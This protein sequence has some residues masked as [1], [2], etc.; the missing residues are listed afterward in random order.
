MILIA[1]VIG[2]A[3]LAFART[4]TSRTE[5]TNI[6][7]LVNEVKQNNVKTL[8]EAADYSS[9]RVV[10]KTGSEFVVTKPSNQNAPEMLR[11]SYGITAD[12]LASFDY[13]V[14]TVPLLS[15]FFSSALFYLLPLLMIGL[16]FF[17]TMRRAQT[18]AD[19][20]FSFG[21]SKARRMSSETPVV[22]FADVAGCDEAK[23]ELVEVVEF[24]KSP[25][26]FIQLG[27]R[28]P[29]GVL[30]VGPPGSGKTLLAKAVAG[31]AGVPFFSLSGS[32]F[33]ELFVGVGASRVRD[34]FEQAK[35]ASPCI[36][37]IDEI[38]AV[39]RQRGAGLGGGNDEREQTLNQMLVE[40]DGFNTE[41]NVIVIAA[42]NRPDILDPALLR[43]GRFDRRVTVDAPDVLGREQ[44][45]KVHSRG[46]PIAANVDMKAIA[47]QTPGFTGADI[48]NLVNEA[49]ILT[50]R[51]NRKEITQKELQEAIEKVA[52]GPERKS[53]LIPP[54]SKEI[55]AYHEAGHA[56]SAA[57]LPESNLSLQKV[58]II[59]RGQTGGAAWYAPEEEDML[60]NTT[61][62]SIEARLVVSMAGRAA[63]EIMF[64]DVTAGAVA[65]IDSAS[66]Q[67]RAMVRRYG[68][69]DEIGPVSFGDRQ[70]LVFLGRELSE[71]RNYSEKV[72]ETIDNEVIKILRTAY[73]RSKQLLLDNKEKF[74]AVAQALLERESLDSVEFR[75]IM[76]LPALPPPV[77]TP[78]T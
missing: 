76:G 69:S 5:E 54:K 61:R 50:A 63:E 57:M 56:V 78:G 22:T 20:A 19:Q 25:E 64:G 48:E 58:S 46:K 14:E 10:R 15:Q 35:K 16:F 49:A 44:I 40:M 42:T 8:L 74:V 52:L 67:A 38:D 12:Q 66:S 24:L 34:L 21:R 65:D 32:E 55:I 36:I 33:V 26:K 62:K 29:K 70:E 4:G 73:Q 7:M 72:A 6:N 39:G 30:L 1:L 41:T 28:I 51:A 31:E 77:P 11:G 9:V 59:P 47:R 37:F 17:M 27:A 3:M 75:E 18:G 71:G 23:A 45:L 60:T 13:R 2:Y 68:M 53:R 43:P